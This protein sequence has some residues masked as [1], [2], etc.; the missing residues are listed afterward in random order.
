MVTTKKPSLML[1]WRSSISTQVLAGPG[2]RKSASRRIILYA[3]A[4]FHGVAEFIQLFIDM[5]RTRGNVIPPNLE[6]LLSAGHRQ[7][8]RLVR[9]GKIWLRF[10]KRTFVLSLVPL[11]SSQ[12]AHQV[13]G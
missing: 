10:R 2:F 7:T 11:N 6:M 13:F 12:P 5:L 4:L 9:Y 1:S 3:A 8:S